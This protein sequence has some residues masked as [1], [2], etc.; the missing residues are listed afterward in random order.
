MPTYDYYCEEN[1]RTVRVFHS[2]H[3]RVRTWGE[4][5]GHANCD[6]GDTTATAPVQRL[7]G[8]GLLRL[9]AREGSDTGGGHG[10]GGCCGVPGCG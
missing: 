5:C 6:T 1:G 10:A 3:A 9:S 8:G 2:I 7:I 4:V